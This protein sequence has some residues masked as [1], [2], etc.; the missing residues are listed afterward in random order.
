MYHVLFK[1]NSITVIQNSVVLISPFIF[2]Y[3]LMFLCYHGLNQHDDRDRALHQLIDC[4]TDYERCGVFKHHSYNIAGHCMLLVGNVETARNMFLESAQDTQ[5]PVCPAFNKYNAA[6]KYL[7]LL[8][9][10]EGLSENIW[11]DVTT[12]ILSSRTVIEYV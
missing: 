1:L 12:C 4:L 9:S 11:K 2:A 3:F 6:Y 5:I 8:W 7:S 10:N